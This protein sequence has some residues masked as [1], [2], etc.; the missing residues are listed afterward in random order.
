MASDFWQE[1]LAANVVSPLLVFCC[2]RFK[3]FRNRHQQLRVEVNKQDTLIIKH[4]PNQ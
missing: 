1:S 3:Y 4:Q 2:N